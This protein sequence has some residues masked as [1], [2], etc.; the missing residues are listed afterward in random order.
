[1]KKEIKE[2][3]KSFEEFNKQSNAKEINLEQ[4]G[5]KKYYFICYQEVNSSAR[6]YLQNKVIEIDPLEWQMKNNFIDMGS[7]LTFNRAL[8]SF[9]Q[10]SKEQFEKFKKWSESQ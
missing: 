3:R 5:L 4:L 7:G 2:E 6:R 1:M 9:S 10:V 8:L